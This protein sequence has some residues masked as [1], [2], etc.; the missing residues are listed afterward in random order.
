MSHMKRLRGERCDS[1]AGVWIGGTD[2]RVYRANDLEPTTFI[3][4]GS[5]RRHKYF[6]SAP[7]LSGS[8]P[9]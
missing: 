3:S 6:G 2:G 4:A 8:R 5:K 1:G 9:G 7:A